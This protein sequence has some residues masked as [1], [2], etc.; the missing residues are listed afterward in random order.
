MLSPLGPKKEP[1]NRAS[2]AHSARA[3]TAGAL[4]PPVSCRR[5][6]DVREAAQMYFKALT[7]ASWDG[8]E[9]DSDEPMS[10]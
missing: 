6:G 7:L 1:T 2:F 5:V 8:S 10:P 4:A 9:A 3:E